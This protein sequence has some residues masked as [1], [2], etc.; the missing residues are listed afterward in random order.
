MPQTK[1]KLTVPF[2]LYNL[3]GL[4]ILVVYLTLKRL[5]FVIWI[6][7]FMLIFYYFTG[8]ILRLSLIIILNKVSIFIHL[9]AATGRSST[10]T[11]RNQC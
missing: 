11:V 5:G 4:A 6:Y 10:R 8:C 7:S 3:C 2:K 9:E 1:R